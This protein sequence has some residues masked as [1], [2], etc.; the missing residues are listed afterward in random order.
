MNNKKLV[1]LIVILFISTFLAAILLSCS[2]AEENKNDTAQDK[3]DENSINQP[4]AA[5][6]EEALPSFD[7]EGYEFTIL[8]MI[9]SEHS[10]M[11]IIMEAVEEIGEPI[12][13]AAYKR[14]RELEELLNIK[15][16]EVN[17]SNTHQA[18]RTQFL[19]G[20]STYDLAMLI[21]RDVMNLAQQNMVAR[22]DELPNIQLDKIWWDQNAR[23]V[24]SVGGKL[25][26]LPGAYQLSNLDLTRFIL[27]NKKILTDID[28]GDLYQLVKDGTWTFDKLISLSRQNSRDLNGDGVYDEND[29]YGLLSIVHHISSSIFFYGS[30]ETYIKKD[31]D[32]MPYFAMPGNERGI[33]IYQK[34]MNEL[35]DGN[36]YFCAQM[37]KG[38]IEGIAT[39][40][41]AED[42]ALFYAISLNRIPKFRDM[43]SPFGILPPPK[44]EGSQN[45]YY[46]ETG[47]GLLGMVPSNSANLERAS[48][49]WD[50]YA[51]LSYKYV[52][53]AYFEVSL[54]TKFARDS[55][56]EDM[57][58]L[59]YNNLW[60]DLGNVYW[61]EDIISKYNDLFI[62]KDINIV[63][64]TEAIS[65]KVNKI[66]SDYIDAF[67]NTD[68]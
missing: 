25:F 42:R 43:D 40:M 44:F 59:I 33:M 66:I 67:I 15:F 53:P 68:N 1:K 18:A 65:D 9:Q 30:G 49:V 58:N 55:E 57:L 16:K 32:D 11:N 5:E 61:W 60:Y 48:A 26:S 13:D 19:S 27:F 37:A 64:A 20:D 17:M 4:D 39:S 8:N 46:C 41:F 34:V 14:S 23:K 35:N 22:I 29:A 2:N 3:M 62:K 51:Q 24:F 63:S 56:S 6:I 45:R 12:N 54:K 10:Y 36:Y 28:G 38:D 50:A 52:L 7:F 21:D 31:N 47:G